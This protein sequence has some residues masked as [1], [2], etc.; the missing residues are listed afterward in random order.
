MKRLYR[1]RAP[2]TPVFNVA[3]L[4]RSALIAVFQNKLVVTERFHEIPFVKSA[5]VKAY[6]IGKM[7]WEHHGRGYVEFVAYVAHG[8][9]ESV[10]VVKHGAGIND[11]PDHLSVGNKF[12]PDSHAFFHTRIIA[13][14][15]ARE[16]RFSPVG[17]F[18]RSNAV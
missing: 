17:T 2:Y 1:F 6:E 7:L 18:C 11:V 13:Q 4:T 10:L 16:K 5:I 12:R 9:V 3:C 8:G 15:A 14:P